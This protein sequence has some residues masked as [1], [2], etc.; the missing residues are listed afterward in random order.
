MESTIEYDFK[1]VILGDESTG[2]T[3]FMNQRT[4]NIFNENY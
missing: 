1:I 3:S 4:K 2:K